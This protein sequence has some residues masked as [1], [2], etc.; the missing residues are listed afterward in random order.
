MTSAQAGPPHAG[1]RRRLRARLR[2]H[3]LDALLVTRLVNIRY[4]T[5]FTGSAGALLVTADG[6]ADL[7]VTDE[8]YTEQAEGEV[9]DLEQL[10]SRGT[11]W[12]T[13]RLGGRRALGLESHAIS[14]DRAR[15]LDESVPDVRVEPAPGHVEALRRFKDAG[16]LQ[17]LAQACA[18]GDA[19]FA[20]LLTW[21]APGV[22]ERQVARR[23]ERDIV[24]RGA[25]APAFPT[26]IAG[27]P[28]A[29][30][31]H[32]PPGD[33]PLARGDLVVMDFGA[34]VSGYH[35]DMTR[36]V[37]LGTPHEELRAV[38]DLVLAAQRHGVAAAVDGAPAKAVDAACRDLISAAGRG[39]AFLH[40][41]GHALG[42]EIHEDPILR[43]DTTGTLR[44]GMAITVEPGVYLPGLG[45]VRIE[46]TIA[47]RP[48]TPNAPAQPDVLTRAPKDLVVL[49]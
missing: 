29:A 19:A 8:R 39:E 49:R 33:R 40:P 5:G 20:D 15:T 11:G 6:G 18:I 36:T 12:L 42:L 35:S 46:D 10:R 48:P 23:L 22:T 45:G 44:A 28:N 26:I 17:L 41:A 24:D 32:H 31:P 30:R 34:L 43:P 3:G 16:E 7:F 9:S 47:V 21:L 14:W 2:E 13:D 38:Y 25:E 4:L 37:A 1:R 27:G